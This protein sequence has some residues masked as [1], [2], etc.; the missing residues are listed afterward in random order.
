ML[1]SCHAIIIPGNSS[2]QALRLLP[3]A[4][5]PATNLSLDAAN[6]FACSAQYC[7]GLTKAQIRWRRLER[8]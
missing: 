3:E 7:T 4:T 1:S 2:F 5:L 6:P 8:G